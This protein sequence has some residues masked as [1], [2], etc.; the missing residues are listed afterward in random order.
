[1][2]ERHETET[3]LAGVLRHAMGSRASVRLVLAEDGEP[4]TVIRTE[5]QTYRCELARF[6]PESVDSAAEF[7][8][9][10]AETLD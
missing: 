6:A 10:L 7:A 4:I 9:A 2:T 5:R 3:R 8:A 1:M